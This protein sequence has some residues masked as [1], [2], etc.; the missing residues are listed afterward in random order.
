LCS[1]FEIQFF[2]YSSL[3]G[4]STPFRLLVNDSNNLAN[5][6]FN[7]QNPTKILIHGFGGNGQNRG[8]ID[9]KNGRPTNAGH[10]CNP[11]AYN[12]S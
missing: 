2:I 10:V 8:I 5:S 1:L 9:I 12:N 4:G 7:P 6:G 11:T 3:D